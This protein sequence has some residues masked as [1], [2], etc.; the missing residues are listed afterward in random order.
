MAVRVCVQH[1]STLP[2][3]MLTTCTWC[4]GV[5][6]GQDGH[7]SRAI[8]ERGRGGAAKRRAYGMPEAL[9]C[10]PRWRDLYSTGVTLFY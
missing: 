1:F 6:R 4:Q 10:I 8:L 5:P 2:R 9:S 7:A 3:L